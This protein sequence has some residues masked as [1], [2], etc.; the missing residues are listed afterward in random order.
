MRF[1]RWF[2]REFFG[3]VERTSSGEEGSDILERYFEFITVWTFGG[4][5]LLRGWGEVRGLLRYFLSTWE[6]LGGG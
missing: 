4:G 2:G 3:Y 1:C 6:E 5:L